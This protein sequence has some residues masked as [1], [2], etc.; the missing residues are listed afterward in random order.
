M[1]KFKRYAIM[2]IAGVVG[3]AIAFRTP[4]LKDY[5]VPMQK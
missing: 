3:V 4:V 1:A 2:A 5:I